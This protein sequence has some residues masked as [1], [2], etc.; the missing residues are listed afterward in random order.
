MP[1]AKYLTL[2]CTA[3]LWLCGVDMSFAG[4]S[5]STLLSNNG[6]GQYTRA[7]NVRSKGCPR[8]LKLGSLRIYLTGEQ[9]NIFNHGTDGKLHTGCFI[10][11]NSPLEVKETSFFPSNTFPEYKQKR[12]PDGSFLALRFSASVGGEQHFLAIYDRYMELLKKQDAKITDL[13][14]E[15]GFHVYH[16]TTSISLYFSADPQRLMANGKPITFFCTSFGSSCETSYLYKDVLFQARIN[17]TKFIPMSEWH[18]FYDLFTQ[19]MHVIIIDDA[20]PLASEILRIENA[21]SH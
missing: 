9:G 8:Y 16:Y 1:A 19:Y 20:A 21:G 2:I 11:I 17:K 5:E 6:S 13:P 14:I 4:D 10:G 18:H 7:S 3:C 12:Q 15:N